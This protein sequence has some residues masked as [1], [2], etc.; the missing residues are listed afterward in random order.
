M[1]FPSESRHTSQDTTRVPSGPH[2]QDKEPYAI[3]DIWPQSQARNPAN[4]QPVVR[5][6]VPPYVTAPIRD[7]HRPLVLVSDRIPKKDMVTVVVGSAEDR[8]GP[9][10]IVV[11]STLLRHVSAAWDEILDEYYKKINVYPRKK[12]NLI[13]KDDDPD[14]LTVLMLLTHH[15]T[16]DMP[17]GL[18]FQ[19]LVNL[20]DT[21]LRYGSTHLVA[22][23]LKT[24]T[25]PYREK[26]LEPGLEEWLF[27]A[28]AFGYENDFI[29]LAQHLTLSCRTNSDGELLVPGTK[30]VI[31][32]R[33]PGDTLTI[34]RRA[35]LRL[36][37]EILNTTYQQVS[38]LVESNSCQAHNSQEHQVRPPSAEGETPL[39]TDE[40]LLRA[41]SRAAAQAVDG[42]SNGNGIAAASGATNTSSRST[43]QPSSQEDDT[44]LRQILEARRSSVQPP[45]F[46]PERPLITELDAYTCT[47]LNHGC[48]LRHLHHKSLWPERSPFTITQSVN[49]LIKT[50]SKIQVLVHSDAPRGQNRHEQCNI[51][52]LLAKML[53]INLDEACMPAS[54]ETLNGLRKNA[55][56]MGWPH[57]EKFYWTDKKDTA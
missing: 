19:D 54:P 12:P 48:L 18:K 49:E 11:L 10:E 37:N 43:T 24:W 17:K 38:R 23:Y 42:S 27:V 41:A 33:F 4:R 51:G 30:D 36:I 16:H 52:S 50:L 40:E 28:H 47:L 32:G 6:N 35:R 22:K 2:A 29:R 5:P 45:S 31:K 25:Q 44:I 14:M 9:R 13:L 8:N 15:E 53:K 20:A 56:K 21:S 46:P 7:Y 34:I 3:K 55:M 1:D 39:P 57:S 26:I